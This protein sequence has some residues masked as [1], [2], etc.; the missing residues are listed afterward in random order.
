MAAPQR[1][2]RALGSSGSIAHP[3]SIGQLYQ[4]PAGQLPAGGRQ[5]RELEDGPL[6]GERREQKGCVRGKSG[7]RKR[8]L[9][10]GGSMEVLPPQQVDSNRWA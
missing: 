8:P 7:G 2:P 6:G 9:E 1:Q 5:I 3:R 10:G 4:V